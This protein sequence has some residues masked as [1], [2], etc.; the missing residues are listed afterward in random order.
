METKRKKNVIP[1]NVGSLCLFQQWK[2]LQ[3][4]LTATRKRDQF[5]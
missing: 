1:F 3:R 4:I 5:Q 2:L